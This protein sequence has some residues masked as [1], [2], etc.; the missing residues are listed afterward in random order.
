MGGMSARPSIPP[1]PRHGSYVKIRTT[2][3]GDE[4]VS[5][6]TFGMVLAGILIIVSLLM[7][8]V[9]VTEGVTEKRPD[10]IPAEVWE[11]MQ[12]EDLSSKYNY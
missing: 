9:E 12:D 2:T 8:P 6:V 11:A 4:G 10:N 7:L 5:L 3:D 1:A